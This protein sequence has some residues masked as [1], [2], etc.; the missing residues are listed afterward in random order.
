[1][2][3]NNRDV[4]TDQAIAG[5]IQAQPDV[6]EGDFGVT[7]DSLVLSI[8]TAADDFT[9]WGLDPVRRDQELRRFWPT[10]PV[11]AS[12]VYALAI[13]NA[14][15]SWTL[16]GPE[17]TVAVV[18]DML[19]MSDLGAGWLSLTTK[20]SIDVMTQDN[21]GFMEVIRERDEP[22]APVLGLA[23]LDA[24]RCV[25]TGNAE[26]PVIYQDAKGTYHRLKRHQV[27]MVVEMPSPVERMRGMQL[28]A[29]SRVLR[30]AQY[31]R[32]IGV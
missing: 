22:D 4:Q 12:A 30:A 11:L 1:M 5:S 9:P 14:V 20:L 16:E 32:D 18:Q 25:R 24:G 29:V 15:F 8:A 28:C 6:N 26:T 27:V 2:T 21:G 3:T 31:L 13:R 17:L 10:E 7:L 23:H 19:A